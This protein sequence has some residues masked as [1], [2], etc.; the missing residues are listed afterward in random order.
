VRLNVGCGDWHLPDGWTNIDARASVHPDVLAKVPPLPFPDASV[1]EIYCGHFVEHLTP[2]DA[3][4]FLAECYRVL[5]PGGRLGVVVPDTRAICRAY[6]EGHGSVEYPEG[7]VRPMADLDEVCAMF[8]YSS[9]QASP[10]RWSYDADTLRRLL[11]RA[12]FYPTSEIDRYADPRIPVHNWYSC[13]WDAV[14]PG[15]AR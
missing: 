14:K 1:E 10:H 4:R 12:G 5:A 3:D 13:G 11:L 2:K 15:G 8:L 7:T 9:V 6:V